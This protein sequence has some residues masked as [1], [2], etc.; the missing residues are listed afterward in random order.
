LE[1]SLL[2]SSILPLSLFSSSI[3]WNHLLL[4]FI[5][6]LTCLY[7]LSSLHLLLSL[8][9]IIIEISLGSAVMWMYCECFRKGFG[10]DGCAL[11]ESGLIKTC[12]RYLSFERILPFYV[13]LYLNCLFSY[14]MMIMILWRNSS[15]GINL[16]DLMVF[17][18]SFIILKQIDLERIINRFSI[19]FP[20]EQ[21]S[22]KQKPLIFLLIL[23][24]WL[25]L[26]FIPSIISTFL[27]FPSIYIVKIIY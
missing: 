9:F 7:I 17:L 4:F 16:I 24:F 15:I 25:S 13:I 19:Y 12:Y 1:S 26:L 21:L 23:L 22:F 3:L 18:L 8:V 20:I 14:P 5:K 27:P 10:S 2:S 11:K 6:T